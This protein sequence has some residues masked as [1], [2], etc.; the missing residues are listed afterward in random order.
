L[1]HEVRDD[2]VKRDPVVEA[3]AGERDEVGDRLRGVGVEQLEGDR[4]VVRVE[5]RIGHG[6]ERNSPVG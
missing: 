2:P 5:R 3:L 6:G 1:D 4:A